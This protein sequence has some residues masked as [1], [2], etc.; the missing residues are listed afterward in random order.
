[1]A[2]IRE[3][4]EALGDD[5]SEPDHVIAERLRCSRSYVR[6][7][8]ARHGVR[9]QSS[10][11]HEGDTIR[12]RW[13]QLDDGTRPVREVAAALGASEG[14]VY[15]LRLRSG[16]YARRQRC[17]RCDF[18][19]DEQVPIVTPELERRLAMVLEGEPRL[20]EERLCLW[21]WLAVQ[22]VDGA[23]F[24]ESGAWQA[25]VDWRP[26]PDPMRRLADA[27]T[28]VMGERQATPQGLMEETGLSG[29]KIHA[30]LR[31]GWTE[32]RARYTLERWE[33]EALCGYAGLEVA[34]FE[35]L[36]AS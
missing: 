20:C 5:G 35:G 14:Y 24:Y 26:E 11:K 12:N 19:A 27:V 17:V 2:T 23:R 25:V 18:L 21:C 9:G 13:E 8:R 7:L 22:G 10:R 1:M 28:G 29:Q 15:E 6:V 34:E 31:W 3:R 36:L 33:L 4:W 30:V 32:F 16:L